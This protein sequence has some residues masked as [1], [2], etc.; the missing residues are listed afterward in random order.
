MARRC[1]RLHPVGTHKRKK[2][3]VSGPNVNTGTGFWH[4]F[5]CF[6]QSLTLCVYQVKKGKG[7]MGGRGE[8][9]YIGYATDIS[10]DSDTEAHGVGENQRSPELSL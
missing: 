10:V 1:G 8:G 2:T 7:E 4:C 9:S 5:L 3:L 6:D